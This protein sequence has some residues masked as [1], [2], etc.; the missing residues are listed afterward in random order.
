MSKANTVEDNF[1]EGL[2]AGFLSQ[3]EDEYRSARKKFP[4]FKSGHEGYGVIL[5]ETEELWELVKKAKNRTSF[6]VKMRK[7]CIQIAAMALAF[8]LELT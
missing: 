6:D 1:V 3:V 2:V 5:E 4:R 7:E 8:Y